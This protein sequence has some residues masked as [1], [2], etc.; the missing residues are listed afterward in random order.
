MLK[1]REFDTSTIGG[2]SEV[3]DLVYRTDVVQKFVEEDDGGEIAQIVSR[4]A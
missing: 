4:Q 3:D 1:A 2:V